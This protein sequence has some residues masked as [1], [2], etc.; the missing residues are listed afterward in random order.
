[1][2]QGKCPGITVNGALLNMPRATECRR[3]STSQ[4]S[5]GSPIYGIIVLRSRLRHWLAFRLFAENDSSDGDGHQTF[6]ATEK[7]AHAF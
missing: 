1:M 7:V 2:L 4:T 5:G 3:L 6:A